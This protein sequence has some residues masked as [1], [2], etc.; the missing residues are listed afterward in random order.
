MELVGRRQ[1]DTFIDFALANNRLFV[2]GHESLAETTQDYREN[3]DAPGNILSKQG[4]KANKMP[5]TLLH[6]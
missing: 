1:Q 6:N 3:K 4:K 2:V 5:P